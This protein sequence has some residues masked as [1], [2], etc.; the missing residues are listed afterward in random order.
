MDFAHI[1]QSIWTVIV[2]VLFVGIVIWAWSSKNK[3]AFDEAARIPMEDDQVN[4]DK[5]DAS[6]TLEEQEKTDG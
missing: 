3:A 4:D 5:K 6:K 2:F 1:Y